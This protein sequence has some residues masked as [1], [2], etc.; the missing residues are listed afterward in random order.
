MAVQKMNII[1]SGRKY[2]VTIEEGEEEVI[3]TIEKN[4]NRKINEFVKLYEYNDKLD[5]I[6]LILLNCSL[7]LYNLKHS[8][9]DKKL[10]NN[11]SEI[12][13]LIDQIV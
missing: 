3:R 9:Q 5:V 7:D 6:T 13:S 2:P 10:I 4:I 11:I 8:E 1:I 12:E